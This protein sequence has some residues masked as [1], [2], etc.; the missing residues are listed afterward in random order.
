MNRPT[1]FEILADEPDKIAKFYEKTLGWEITPW[2]GGETPYL[3]VT[4]GSEEEAGINGGIMRR[5]FQQAVIN[6]IEV[7]SLDES[8]KRVKA[9]GGKIVDGPNEVSGVGMHAYCADPEGNLFG[10]MQSFEQSS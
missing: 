6:T 7:D 9:T 5:Q 3:L 10:L 8:L 1:H 4:T 2:N